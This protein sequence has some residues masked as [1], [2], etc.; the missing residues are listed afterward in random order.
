MRHAGQRQLAGA[1]A[2]AR[3]YRVVQEYVDEGIAGDVFD[4][5]PDFQKMLAAAGRGEFGGGA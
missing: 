3:G 1:Y 2:A 5:R 4:R